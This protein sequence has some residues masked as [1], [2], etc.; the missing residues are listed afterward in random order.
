M[1]KGEEL[2]APPFFHV[3]LFLHLKCAVMTKNAAVSAASIFTVLSCCEKCLLLLTAKELNRANFK[4]PE[5]F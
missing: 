2:H 4:L 5:Q 3:M 1:K